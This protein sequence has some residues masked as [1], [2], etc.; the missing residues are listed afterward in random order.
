LVLAQADMYQQLLCTTFSKQQLSR[1]TQF[2]AE[3][4]LM[5]CIP[6]KSLLASS[7]YSDVAHFADHGIEISGEVK[8]NLEK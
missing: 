6:S 7:H 5:G 4:V 2:L 3:L 1:N 8:V